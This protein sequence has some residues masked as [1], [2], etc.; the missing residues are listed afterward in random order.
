[1]SSEEQTPGRILDGTDGTD[2]VDE[3][4]RGSNN[5]FETDATWEEILDLLVEECAP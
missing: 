2:P 5:G 4:E 3:V 1:M